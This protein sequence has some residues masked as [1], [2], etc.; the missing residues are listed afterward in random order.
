MSRPP[1]A[2]AVALLMWQLLEVVVRVFGGVIVAAALRALADSLQRTTGLSQKL[3]LDVV[4]AVVAGGLTLLVALTGKR[5]SQEIAGLREAVSEALQRLQQFRVAARCSSGWPRA[6]AASS[7]CGWHASPAA[8]CPT[9]AACCGCRRCCNGRA[10]T[11][12]CTPP[13]TG[14]GLAVIGMPLAATLGVI[15]GP[16][17]FVPFF[18]PIAK[19]ALVV[20][21]ALPQGGEMALQVLALCIAI[22]QFE[23][24]LLR[25]GCSAG[26]SRC[27]RRSS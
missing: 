12:R 24:C 9:T 1:T 14:I 23:N 7:G 26:R 3:A 17:D 18:G 4:V 8:R 13:A 19:A 21:S 5:A 22:Q 10:P 6:A 27:R 15:A 2:V 16:L 11:P 20:L 25:P